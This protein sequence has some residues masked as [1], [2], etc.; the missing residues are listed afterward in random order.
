MA[1]GPT[2]DALQE[3]LEPVVGAGGINAAEW[4][5]GYVVD[6]LAPTAVALPRSLDEL[7]GVLRVAHGLGAAVVPYGGGTMAGLGNPPERYHLAVATGELN[8]VVEYEPADLTVTVQAGM[9]L[10]VLQHI[11]GEHG[12]MLPLDPP[13]AERATV[14]GVIAADASGPW[15]LMY[16]TVRDRLLGVTAVLTDGTVVHG[17]GR[18]VKNVAGYDLPKLFVGS[19]GTLGVI[20]EA[21]F[22]VAPL[23]RGRGTV[24]A[25][26]DSCEAAM[27]VA[28]RLLA[29]G[30]TPMSLDL[31]GPHA[32]RLLTEETRSEP[33]EAAYVLAA[34]LGG[35]RRAVERMGRDLVREATAGGSREVTYLEREQRNAFW[36]RV[37]D[38]GRSEADPADMIVK[39]AVRPTE[40]PAAV[41]AAHRAGEHAGLTPAVI[42]RAGNG[43]VYTYWRSPEPEA[44]AAAAAGLAE[45]ARQMRGAAVVEQ[46]P[47]AVKERL[48]VFGPAGPDLALMQRVKEALDPGR[49]L[50]P[51]RMV[52]RI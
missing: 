31:V 24:L 51:G 21:T 8:R 32:S 25:V 38:F 34:E 22:K 47:R 44:L 33:G 49:L 19:L 45:A 1:E 27:A 2:V 48:D 41:A 42:A 16:G 40:V 3:A 36:R 4:V 50:S 23:P 39:L 30:W 37:R 18:V 52:G 26:F 5:D 20:A 29:A 10:R 28:L 11:L 14:G 6:G 7:S 35:P 46:A 43:A 17:G 12:Q 13:L 9:T 15:R